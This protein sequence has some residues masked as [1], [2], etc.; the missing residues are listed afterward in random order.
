MS[1]YIDLKWYKDK[2]APFPFSKMPLNEF[3][4]WFLSNKELA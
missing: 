1:L 3:F 2:P 4:V